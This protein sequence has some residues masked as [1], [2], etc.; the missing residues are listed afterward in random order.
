MKYTKAKQKKKVPC[1][2]CK[3]SGLF[4]EGE[5]V[6]GDGWRTPDIECDFCNGTGMIVIGSK[7]HKKYQKLVRNI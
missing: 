2:I 6:C 3:G 4:E 5:D 7:E 1:W